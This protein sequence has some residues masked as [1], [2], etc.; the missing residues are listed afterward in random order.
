M[1]TGIEL[2][3]IER[4]EQLTKHGRT[5]ELDIEYNSMFQ[6]TKA[7]SILCMDSY[8][9]LDLASE[10]YCPYGWDKN[11]WKRMASK[12]YEERVKIAGALLAAEL[13]RI[14]FKQDRQWIK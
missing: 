1:K 9:S 3:T 5:L 13:D 8:G 12:P 6:L 11:I 2:I 14:N 10:D 4:L 7:A